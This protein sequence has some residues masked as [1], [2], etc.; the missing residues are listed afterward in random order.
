MRRTN[1]A[2]DSPNRYV[3]TPS[4]FSLPERKMTRVDRLFLSTQTNNSFVAYNSLLSG[5]TYVIKNRF[6]VKKIIY[7]KMSRE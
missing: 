2:Y 3:S 7:L 6:S 5:R 4:N 1:E